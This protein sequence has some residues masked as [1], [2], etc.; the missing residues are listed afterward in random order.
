MTIRFYRLL[1]IMGIVM[2]G[3]TLYVAQADTKHAHR[4]AQHGLQAYIDPDSKRFTR[5]P[6][7]Q[8]QQAAQLR[9]TLPAGKPARQIYLPDG[10]VMLDLRQHYL[11][12]GS[13][14]APG[15]ANK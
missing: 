14:S 11:L 15:G 8:Q 4:I 12:R 2:S 10:A 5:P 3:H 6:H 13:E 1:A 9:Q 7:Q